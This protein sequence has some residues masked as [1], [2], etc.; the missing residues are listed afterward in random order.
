MQV[1]LKDTVDQ[2]ERQVLLASIAKFKAGANRQ[3]LQSTRVVGVTCAASTFGCLTALE[4]AV[5]ILDECCQMTEPNALLP[6]A[7]FKC[8]QLML[9][10]DPKQLAPTV[11]GGEAAHEHGLE[12]TL[13]SRLE[14]MGVTT[15]LLRTQYRCHPAI[16]RVSNAL[17]YD[18]QLQD[19]VA[20]EERAGLVALPPL[21][22]FDVTTGREEQDT[23][24]SYKNQAEGLFVVGLL[25]Y[26]MDHGVEA[27]EIGVICLYKAQAQLVQ[28]HVNGPHGL[29]DSRG[30]QISTVDAFQGG[31]KK[32]IILSCVRTDR[33]GFIDNPK[34]VNV[35]LTRG[36]HHLF[37]AGRSWVL[38]S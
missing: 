26:L 24:N 14:R 38:S 7:R 17:F 11:S 31:E 10:G 23:S 22:W 28:L 16:S 36:K 1:M 29:S 37:I 9:V 3:R 6:I 15:V 5:V 35:A 4:F 32:I 13:F 12:Q 33:V 8:R 25:R 20:K 27:S 2:A 18:G 19:G 30:L 21:A 34:R